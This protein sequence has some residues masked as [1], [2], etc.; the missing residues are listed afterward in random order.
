MLTHTLSWYVRVG[1]IQCIVSKVFYEYFG[2]QNFSKENVVQ[3]IAS[4]K[5]F[6][7]ERNP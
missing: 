5:I 2:N 6:K 7:N 3:N 4:Y 1:N